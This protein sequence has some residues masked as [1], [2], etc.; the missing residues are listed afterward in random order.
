[1]SQFSPSSSGA[2]RLE[3]WRRYLVL[4]CLLLMALALDA[5]ATTG[6]PGSEDS[7]EA[8]GLQAQ[9]E[10]PERQRMLHRR[11][12]KARDRGIYDTA[13]SYFVEASDAGYGPASVAAGK[14]FAAGYPGM[15]KNYEAAAERYRMAVEQ[16]AGYVAELPLGACYQQGLGVP[17]DAAE[18]ERWFRRGALTVAGL[19]DVVRQG[20][21][22]DAEGG[23]NQLL[24]TL[25]SP[26]PVPAEFEA[27]V[28]WVAELEALGGPALYD[29]SEQYRAGEGVAADGLLSAELLQRAFD[30]DHPEAAYSLAQDKLNGSADSRDKI[31]GIDLLWRAAQSDH[32]VAQMELGQLYAETE[33][34]PIDRQRAYYWLMRAHRNGA[35]IT[36][37]LEDVAASLSE[38]ERAAVLETLDQGLAYLP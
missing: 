4:P 8:I 2:G 16:G 34:D 20:A 3:A 13:L 24:E 12:L 1:M 11:G 18:A 19:R 17:Q 6:G 38:D 22:S 7:T 21:E 23:W 31:A 15:G 9:V 33:R 32:V 36:G 5:C 10:A 27:A 28:G 14:I 37:Q 26:H 29:L 30:R 25:F 35:E